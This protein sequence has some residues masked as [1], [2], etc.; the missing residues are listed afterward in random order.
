MKPYPV[1]RRRGLTGV[2]AIG[3]AA[4]LI[5]GCEAMAVT[6]FGVGAATGVT[7]TLNGRA[8]RT[9]TAPVGDVKQATLTALNLM[10]IKVISSKR[11]GNEE[12]ILARATDREIEIT[13]EVLSP[14]STRMRSV[15][16]QGLVYDSATSLEI[17]LQTER[18]M[19][20]G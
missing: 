9:F 1:S 7:Q 6:A 5:G 12:V 17:V 10:G 4:L 19:I 15:T 14:N 2:I 18:R 20:N 13:L 16:T 11:N 3:S 8:Y